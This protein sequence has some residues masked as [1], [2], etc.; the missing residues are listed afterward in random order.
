MIFEHSSLGTSLSSV[1]RNEKIR[2]VLIQILVMC[3]VFLFLSILIRNMFVNLESVGKELSFDFLLYPAAYDI[4]FSPFLDYSSRSSHLKA[5]I[6]GL[7]NTLLVSGCGILMATIL[8]VVL[9][10]LRLSKNWLVNRTVYTYVEFSRNVPLLLHI[11]FI[12]GII[13]TALPPAKKS[14]N[15]FDV[16]YLS[17]RG[18]YTPSPIWEEGSG[19]LLLVFILSI[20]ATI[21]FYFWSKNNQSKTGTIRPVFII[22]IFILIIPVTVAYV[23]SGYPVSWDVPELRGFNFKG[24]APIK[25]EFLAL[26]FALSYYT[27]SFIAEIVRGGILAVDYGQTEAAYAIGLRPN[28]TLQLII[29]P[30]ALR[31]IVPPLASQ[32]LNL[33]K[34]SSLA[35]AIGYMDLVA[36]VGGISLMQT[37][38]EVETM[39]IVL[40]VYL[41]ISLMISAFMNWFNYK[42][43]LVNR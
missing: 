10:V 15:F 13:V 6:V 12:Y 30:Q 34:N 41:I 33:T 5:A 11:L 14:I 28:R 23:V 18:L 17:N 32:Y 9:G 1:W 20:L 40:C 26:W 7:L 16:V 38:K 35:I 43:R 4:S 29:L 27:A 2:S 22:S 3:L 37:G 21:I 19:L 31:V 24:G 8:G 39:L 25:P 36:T 42:T